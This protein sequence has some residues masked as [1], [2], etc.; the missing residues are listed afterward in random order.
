MNL[1]AIKMALAR[2][3]YEDVP[4]PA[5]LHVLIRAP[6][7]CRGYSTCTQARSVPVVLGHLDQTVPMV[8]EHQRRGETETCPDQL[9]RNP[10]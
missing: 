7:S 1:H 10:L 3:E 5:Y 2:Q 9:H 4:E 8:L 6:G